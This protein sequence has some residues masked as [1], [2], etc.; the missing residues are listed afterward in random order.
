MDG[1][2]ALF[3]AGR[4]TERVNRYLTAELKKHGMGALGVSHTEIIGILTRIDRVQL[5]ELAGFI[6]KDKSTITALTG[7][8]LRMGY[9]RRTTSP[10]DNRVVYITLTAKGRELEPAI[11]AISRRMRKKAFRGFGEDEKQVL[12]GLL[13]RIRK[14]F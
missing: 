9:I 10:D 4:V 3:I 5:K 2:L 12:A 13:E 1:D 11:T 14:N 8:L 6:G 7:K